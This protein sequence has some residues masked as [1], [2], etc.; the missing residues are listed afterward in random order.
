MRPVE[1]NLGGV[2]RDPSWAL[3]MADARLHWAA[4]QLAGA[5]IAAAAVA[6]AV[7]AVG[8]VA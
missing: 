4:E 1:G 8:A 6:G 5:V 7:T 3:A 2:W